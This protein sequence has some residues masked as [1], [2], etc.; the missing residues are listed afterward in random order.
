MKRMTIDQINDEVAGYQG[1]LSPIAHAISRCTN[2][3][4]DSLANDLDQMLD[5]GRYEPDKSILFLNG[6][7]DS[8][9]IKRRS[10]HA[11]LRAVSGRGY[12]SRSSGR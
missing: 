2:R 4:L 6:Q 8:G 12:G 10:W 7:A 9:T 1:A 5:R 3:A 11:R